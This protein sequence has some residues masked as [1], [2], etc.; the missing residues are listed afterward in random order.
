[1]KLGVLRVLAAKIPELLAVLCVRGL[2]RFGSVENT[3]IAMC[4]RLLWFGRR[5]KA[6]TAQPG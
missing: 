3:I 4:E 2:A 1:M 6:S 5:C